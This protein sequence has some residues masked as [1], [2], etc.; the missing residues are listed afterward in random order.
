[1]NLSSLPGPKIVA[2]DW[3]Y[4]I[5]KPVNIGLTSQGE[6]DLGPSQHL[7]G[8]QATLSFDHKTRTWWLEAKG[9]KGLEVNASRWAKGAVYRMVPSS[10]STT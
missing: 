1:M 6:I 8:Q 7:S 2:R 3:V 4:P 10:K 9:D 5:T